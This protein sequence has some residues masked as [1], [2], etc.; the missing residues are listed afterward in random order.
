MQKFISI[1][2]SAVSRKSDANLCIFDTV[3]KRINSKL[4]LTDRPAS[5]GLWRRVGFVIEII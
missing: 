4:Q 2:A 1:A 5:V 3:G